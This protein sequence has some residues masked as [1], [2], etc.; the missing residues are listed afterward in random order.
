M[1]RNFGRRQ[2]VANTPSVLSWKL[3]GWPADKAKKML[4]T[5][6]LSACCVSNGIHSDRQSREARNTSIGETKQ[7]GTNRN[8]N[9][10]RA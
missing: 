6:K 4:A 10:R 8:V 1:C 5:R 7:R 9:S 2:C 3:Q